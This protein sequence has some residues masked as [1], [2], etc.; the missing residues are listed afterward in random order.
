MGQDHREVPEVASKK[1]WRSRPRK[2]GADGSKPCSKCGAVKPALDFYEQ[3]GGKYLSA[4]CKECCKQAS[5]QWRKDLSPD[6]R[7]AFKVRKLKRQQEWLAANSLH[8][9][10]WHRARWLRLKYGLTLDDWARLLESQGRACA[11]CSAAPAGGDDAWHT[12]HCHESGNVRGILCQACN[13]ALGACGDTAASLDRT[14][15]N[16]LHYL[17]TVPER[18][19][20]AGLPVPAPTPRAFRPSFVTTF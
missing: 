13:L 1:D 9:K 20:A 10:Q 15:R 16:L 4:R 5:R 17:A 3:A 14:A 18:M 6:E 8:S 7:E 19:A 12:D 11:S 2:R